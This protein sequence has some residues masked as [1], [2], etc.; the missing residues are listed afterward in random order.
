MILIWDNGEDYSNH[1]IHF[2]E[3]G[4]VDVDH[5]A[6]LLAMH[7]S[8]GRVVATTE[9]LEW[10]FG[11]AAHLF[12]VISPWLEASKMKNIPAELGGRLFDY[13]LRRLRNVLVKAHADR[14]K[15]STWHRN[16]QNN[17]DSTESE[18]AAFMAVSK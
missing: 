15:E 6:K 1:S 9:K 12:D 16:I 18:R 11:E 17:I 7:D 5:A 10:R 8:E 4:E 13:E 3:I 14:P 2:V